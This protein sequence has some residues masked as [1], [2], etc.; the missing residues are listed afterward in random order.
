MDERP[1]IGIA[2]ALEQ[3][4]YGVWDSLCA[5]TPYSYVRAVQRAGGLALLIPAD[6]E[7]AED[8]EP[9]LERIDGLLLAGGSDIDPAC[10]DAPRHPETVGTTPERDRSELALAGAAWELGMP[11][12]GICRGMQ[13]LNVARGGTLHQHLPDLV[14]HT[15]HR[16]NPG[17]FE[18]SEHEVMLEPASLAAR[19]AGEQRHLTR[20]HHHQGIDRIGEG[21]VVSGLSTLDGL[22]EAIEA[23]GRG[24]VLGVQWHPEADP[25]SRIV[26]SLVR[27]ADGARQSSELR[28]RERAVAA[29]GSPRP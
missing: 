24:Y 5:L 16:R 28:G 22:P 3:A 11:L 23:P 15:E 12:L 13:L 20:S 25:G 8:P 21:L 10:Y 1:V 14:G 18:G 19:S 2:A 6:P 26:D 29:P 27:A 4:R 7:L 9:V 17:S